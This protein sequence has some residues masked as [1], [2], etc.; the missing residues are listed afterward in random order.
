MSGS[1]KNTAR[2][3]EA[4]E[5]LNEA[6]AELRKAKE[7][8]MKAAPEQRAELKTE[9][10]KLEWDVANAAWAVAYAENPQNQRRLDSLQ[11]DIDLKRKAYELLLPGQPM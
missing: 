10:A 11:K 4:I 9:V 7:N 1:D 6:K 2:L 3:Q 8:F 5:D